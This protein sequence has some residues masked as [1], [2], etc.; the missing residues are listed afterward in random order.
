MTVTGVD[1]AAAAR[2]IEEAGKS[3]KTAIVMLEGSC[4]R[5]EAEAR[6]ARANGFVRA[7]LAEAP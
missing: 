5:A 7:A 1:Y 4:S 6:L 3:V 2:A